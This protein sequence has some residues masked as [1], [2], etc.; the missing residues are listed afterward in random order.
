MGR[1]GHPIEL[2]SPT[3]SVRRNYPTP[4]TDQCPSMTALSVGISLDMKVSPVYDYTLERL[5]RITAD[6]FAKYQPLMEQ[7]STVMTSVLIS[8]MYGFTEISSASR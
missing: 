1:S 6:S 4:S 7:P 3:S 2:E 5:V 8:N